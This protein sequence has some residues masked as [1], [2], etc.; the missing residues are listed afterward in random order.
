VRQRLL[1]SNEKSETGVGNL[2][3]ALALAA[4]PSVSLFRAGKM[5]AR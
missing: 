2:T 5:P 3:T 4:G 1:L